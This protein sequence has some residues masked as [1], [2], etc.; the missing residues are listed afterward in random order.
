MPGLMELRE[1]NPLVFDEAQNL[2]DE[3]H[4]PISVVQTKSGFDLYWGAINNPN[5]IIIV[6]AAQTQ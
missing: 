5:A 1:K 3:R 4:K 6:P 2:A